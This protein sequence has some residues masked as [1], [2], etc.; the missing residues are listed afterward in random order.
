M[1]KPS[2]ILIILIITLIIVIILTILQ[3]TKTYDASKLRIFFNM[4]SIISFILL[5][6]GLIMT[7]YAIIEG[8]NINRIEKTNDS[9]DRSYIRPI[10]SM[11][12][13]FD[14][15]P[16]FVASL[17]PQKNI[18]Q[19]KNVPNSVVDKESSVL[20]LSAIM[21][22]AMEDQIVSDKYD[23]A[24]WETTFLQWCS[25]KKFYEMF[26]SLYP[27]YTDKTVEYAKIMFEYAK[28]YPIHSGE[29][30]ERVAKLVK[31]DT[32]FKNLKKKQI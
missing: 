6:I 11:N 7:S 26:L 14:N 32:R 3:N 4:I 20:E 5:G 17:W 28:K 21:L 12:E 29:E 1:F 23:T 27:N 31:E 25:S 15:C 9:V 22:Q 30:L 24:E 16:N 10:K 18:F 8:Q 2:Q 13:L 19:N